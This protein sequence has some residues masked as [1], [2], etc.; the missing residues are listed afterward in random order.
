MNDDEKEMPLVILPEEEGA[1]LDQVLA[2]RYKDAYSRT[3][4]QKLIED[5]LVLLNGSIVKKRE[6]LKSG[7]EVEIE[8]VLNRECTLLEE[9]IPLDILFE[10]EEIIVVNKP[11]GLV[12]HPAPGNWSKTFVNALLYHVKNLSQHIPGERPGI[13]HRLDKDT[14]GVMV[15]A[16]TER[17]Q[18]RLVEAFSE[19]KVKKKYLAIAIGNPGAMTITKGIERDPI[20]R[21]KMRASTTGKEAITII[22][23]LK[24]SKTLSL[25]RLDIKTGRTHQIRVH[26]AS[27]GT[28]VLGDT[29][30]GRQDINKRLHVDKQLL[31]A[32]SLEF[33]HPITAKP[34]QFTAPLPANFTPF[35]EGMQHVDL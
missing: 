15:A 24:A 11:Q 30:Y 4:F 12:V 18:R 23:P 17:A 25:L 10:D 8:F 26:L 13:V 27:V 14:S 21:Q 28:P 31:H 2:S 35:I 34:L 9:P 19:R 22:E 6:K 33:N 3:Y 7:D 5:G 16:K 20:H 32:E 29:V 1:R